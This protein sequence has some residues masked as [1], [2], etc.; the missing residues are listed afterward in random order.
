VDI[1]YNQAAIAPQDFVAQDI[2]AQDFATR[3]GAA[4]GFTTEDILWSLGIWSVILTFS[5]VIAFYMLMVA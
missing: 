3:N 5:P 2:P 1:N 4:Q